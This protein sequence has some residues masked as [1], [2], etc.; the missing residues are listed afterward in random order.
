M[1]G[2]Y[3][4][5]RDYKKAF[6]AGWGV[7]IGVLVSIGVKLTYSIGITYFYISE[8]WKIFFG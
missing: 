2:Q 4:E 5:D 6:A 1:V 3:I 8:I 7:L